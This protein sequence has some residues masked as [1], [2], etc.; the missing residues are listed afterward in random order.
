MP[1]IV[2]VDQPIGRSFLKCQQC[3]FIDIIDRALGLGFRV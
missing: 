3:L 1:K 2:N